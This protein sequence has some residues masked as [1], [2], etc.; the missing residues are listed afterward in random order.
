MSTARQPPADRYNLAH[1]EITWPA[2]VIAAHQATAEWAFQRRRL[3][4]DLV[5]PTPVLDRWGRPQGIP[6]YG[7]PEFARL[8]EHDPRRDVAVLHAAELWRQHTQR[9]PERLR[10]MMSDDLRAA[11]A[12]RAVWEEEQAVE[13]RKLVREVRSWANQPTHLELLARRRLGPVR[14]VRATPDWTPVAIPGRPGWWR[15]CLSDRTQLD[16]PTDRPPSHEVVP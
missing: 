10:R 13:W 2:P 7:A 5:D 1:Q 15:H 3:L 12:L 6:I 8:P 4:L 14:E 9:A 16:L 11:V